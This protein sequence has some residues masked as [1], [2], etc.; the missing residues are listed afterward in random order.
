MNIVKRAEW[1]IERG[2]HVVFYCVEGS[3]LHRETTQRLQNVQTVFKNKKSL[4]LTNGRRLAKLFKVQGADLIWCTDKRDIS[5]LGL[6]KRFLKGKIKFLYHQ[7]MRFGVPKKDF[8]HTRIFKMI[9]H[10][11]APMHYLKEEVVSMSNYPE[12]RIEVIPLC[13]DLGHFVS[14]LPSREDARRY[15]G[16]KDED[17][18][19]GMIG[20]IDYAKSQQFVKDAF[21]RFQ[22]E[23]DNLRLLFVGNKTVEAPDDY[24]KR[25]TTEIEENDCIFLFP[26]MKEVGYFYQAI[27]VF[28]MASKNE[29]FGMVTIE[30]MLA[31][32]IIVGTNSAGTKEL[33]DHEKFGYFFNWID[34]P[35]LH[36]AW[37]RVFVELD[38]AKEKGVK[39]KEM[40]L[41]SFSHEMECAKIEEL[42]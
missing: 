33:L 34:E 9:D 20:R 17:R 36:E 15:F 24:H 27:D 39:A 18:V 6:A 31:E 4:D 38:M 28:V 16:L 30:A 1:M 8:W 21:E 42:F 13:M 37:N 35:S 22:K 41:A 29:T 26:Y 10:W 14:S 3:P 5:V 25:L 19:I 7:Q 23:D 11:I 40:A 32:K 2:H 12:D